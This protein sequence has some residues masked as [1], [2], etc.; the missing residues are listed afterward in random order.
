MRIEYYCKKI[1][2]TFGHLILSCVILG[3]ILFFI[4]IIFPKFMN[5]RIEFQILLSLPILFIIWFGTKEMFE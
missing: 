1:M 5:W 4:M 3:F 2:N